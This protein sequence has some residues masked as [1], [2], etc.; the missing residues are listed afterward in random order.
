MGGEGDK[1]VACEVDGGGGGEG[2][3]DGRAG[4]GVGRGC[5][6]GVGGG[7]RGV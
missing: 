6:H 7:K 2:E 1:I 3:V 5:D 4:D